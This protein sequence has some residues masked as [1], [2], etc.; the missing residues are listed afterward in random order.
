R[1]GRIVASPATDC[2]PSCPRSSAGA[3]GSSRP[4]WVSRLSDWASTTAIFQTGDLTRSRERQLPRQRVRSI[5]AESTFMA[6]ALA[7]LPPSAAAPRVVAGHRRARR[8]DREQPVLQI[9]QRVRQLD[10]ADRGG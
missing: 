10:A 1:G 2:G 7:K 4:S 3:E 5:P 8:I 9:L 6:T